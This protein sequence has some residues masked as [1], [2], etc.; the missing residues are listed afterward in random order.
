MKGYQ[1][2]KVMN[3][4][5]SVFEDAVPDDSQY[6]K[7]KTNNFLRRCGADINKPEEQLLNADRVCEIAHAMFDIDSEEVFWLRLEAAK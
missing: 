4:A 3:A 2:I 6:A 1:A 5:H 7:S